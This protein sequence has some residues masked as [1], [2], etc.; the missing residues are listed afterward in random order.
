VNPLLQ[1]LG[2]P[3]WAQ[4]V[5]ALLHTLWQAAIIAVFLVLLLRRTA[6]P[7]T[8][9]R[10][11]LAALATVLV[12][13]MVSWAVLHRTTNGNT[14]LPIPTS[15]NSNPKPMEIRSNGEPSTLVVASNSR[16]ETTNT[17]RGTAWLALVWLAGAGLMLARAGAQVAG[18]ERLQRSC[19]PVVDSR[20]T[21][22]VAE[23]RRAVGLARQVRIAVTDKLTSPAVLGVLIPTLILPLALVTTLTPEQ[24]R[25]VLLHEF[26]HIRRG[27]YLANLF[28]L[29]AEA[30]LFFNPSVWWISHQTRRE[31]EAC[32][33]ALAIELGGAPT[34]YARTLV[35]VAETMLNPSPA[36]AP[37][38]GNE[39][40]PS[41]LSDRVQRVLVP[42]YRP[43][44]RLT[45]RAMLMALGMGGV[46]LGLSAI[47]T[48]VTVAAAAALLTPAQRMEQIEKKM[49]EYGQKPVVE[50]VTTDGD[51]K[52]SERIPVTARVRT[53][54]GSP[55]P[56]RITAI[57]HSKRERR[58][59][60]EALGT[61]K[62]GWLNTTVWPGLVWIEVQADGFAPAVLGPFDGTITNRIDA[63]DIV[64][65]SGFGVSIEVV[66]SVSGVAVREAGLR[67]QFSV[68]GT[69]HGMQSSRD[70]QTDA[71]GHASLAH[72]VDQPLGVT[73]NAPGYELMEQRF[74]S[75]KP[76]QLLHIA[77]RRGAIAAGVVLDKA[78]GQPL[79]GAKIRL[80]QRNGPEG[81]HG[82]GWEG[83]QGD[84]TTTDS[85]GRF[86]IQQL[87]HDSRYWLG[88]TAS[89]RESALLAEVRP[90]KTNLVARLGPELVVKGRV[91]GDLNDLRQK[92]GD[93]T[94]GV[95]LQDSEI[96][97]SINS[98]EVGVNLEVRD[99]VGYFQFTNR[100]AGPVTISGGGRKFKRVV[101]APV[102]D[103]LLDLSQPA[104]ANAPLPTREVLFRFEHASGVPPRGTVEVSI[105]TGTD[106]NQPTVRDQEM[107]IRDGEVRAEMAI[108]GR[109]SIRPRKTIGYWFKDLFSSVVVTNGDGPMVIE[110]PTVPAGVI[111]A[112]ARLPDGTAAHEVF[113]STLELKPSPQRGSHGS[114]EGGVISS[115]AKWVSGPLP[116]GGTYQIVGQRGNSFC[117][118]EPI[119]LTEEEPTAEV[120]LQFA[121][122]RTMECRAVNTARQAVRDAEVEGLFSLPGHGYGL[123]SQMADDNGQ[124]RI[125]DVTP[126]VGE[127]KVQVKAPGLRAE[128]VKLDFARDLNTIR[129]Q[130]GLKI[131]GQLVEEGTGYII[132]DAEIRFFDSTTNNFPSVATRTDDKGRFE[133]NTLGETTYN[134]Y[135]TGADVLNP[136][137]NGFKAGQ[138]A[139]LKLEVKPNPGSRLVPKPPDRTSQGDSP[140]NK[141]TSQTSDLSAANNAPAPSP[142]PSFPATEPTLQ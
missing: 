73:V 111:Y 112:K 121:A 88:V 114:L 75:L 34:D 49:A 130:P 122:P 81:N 11:S 8:R 56:K 23:A 71:Y 77:V 78:S 125:A 80:Y 126:G 92:N 64:L 3:E 40:A 59:G 115:T 9:Y 85:Q 45:W 127:Y 84:L 99:G 93:H 47:G 13:G 139:P 66:D 51:S 20:V 60:I 31:R 102:G 63:G 30:L 61:G 74:E 24:L 72:C 110:I 103:W 44:L 29:F 105:P 136:Y 76:G 108:G 104:P 137:Q 25:L 38:F 43:S 89:G 14:P 131:T 123:P 57:L 15:N 132:P 39:R 58:S 19:R 79:A 54:D 32:C 83:E 65:E 91:I 17:P 50:R 26:A 18:A 140:A 128:W 106:Q 53:A 70:P 33:D 138:A 129:L 41:S 67:A 134:L 120:E 117:L 116:L 16:A 86:V 133:F 36:A 2:S 135:V 5:K 42:G 113:F 124:F 107:E 118:S 97:N 141:T 68:R 22:L 82:Y 109:T 1:W 46:L 87:R 35:S 28:Q 95:N 94:I 21:E 69:G 55:L 48:R 4:V 90:G 119:A 6:N 7:V 52:D 37:A 96:E 12:I 101:D 98:R 100:I 142:S 62:D 10:C 27:D